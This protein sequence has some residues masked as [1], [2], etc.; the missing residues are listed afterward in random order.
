MFEIFQ[1]IGQTSP[2][3]LFFISIFLL[4]NKNNLLFYYV[5]FFVIGLLINL[6]LKGLIQE[7][8]PSIDTKTFNLMMKNKDR[9]IYKHGIPYDIFGMP[10]GHSQSVLFSTIFIYLSLRD[11]KVLVLYLFIDIITLI[12]RV[13]YNHHTL[14]QVIVGSIVGCLMGY[15]A[16]KFAQT[17]IEGKKS[18]KK[19]DF[20]PI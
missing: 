2:F 14:K 17:N 13:V 1:K 18:V 15:V 11:I 7:P 20:G 8:R 19:D 16:F 4:R 6:I 3:I 12:Q 5:V 9:Y 10:S